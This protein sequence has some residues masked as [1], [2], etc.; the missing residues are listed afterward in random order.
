MASNENPL[1]QLI[2]SVALG[3][4]SLYAKTHEDLPEHS[5]H[6]LAKAVQKRSDYDLPVCIIGAGAAGL[7]TAMIFESLGIKYQIVEANTRKRIGGRLFTHY[8]PGGGDY[9]YFVREVYSHRHR[10]L[11]PVQDL[12][13]M[14]FRNTPFMKRTFDL[15]DNRGLNLKRIPYIREMVNPPHTLLHFNNNRLHNRAGPDAEGADPFKVNSS[16]FLKDNKL[17]TQRAVQMKVAEVIKP[18]RDL[19]RPGSD[20]TLPKINEALD[21]LFEVTNRWSMRTYMLNALGMDANDVNW[22]EALDNS[23]GTYD[24]SLTQCE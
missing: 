15:F 10:T 11:T 4:L 16:K 17:A 2:A 6:K 22:C 24:L 1:C 19:F 5:P 12:G 23:T 20:G 14:R 7:Y 21:Q 9:D 18:F 3:D 8:F 13:A